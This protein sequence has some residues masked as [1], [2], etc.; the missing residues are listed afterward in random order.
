MQLLEANSE[1]I[2][3]RYKHPSVSTGPAFAASKTIVGEFSAR[4]A[5]REVTTE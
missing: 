5:V 2:S 3:I 1:H 4:A